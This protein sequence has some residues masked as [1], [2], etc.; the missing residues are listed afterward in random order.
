M[1]TLDYEIDTVDVSTAIL[2]SPIKEEV[3]MKIPSGYTDDP[4]GSKKMLPLP[5]C[6]YGLKQ[7][8]GL[9][10]ELCA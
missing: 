1:A 10:L 5:K 4:G 6:L 3:Y 8:I 2:L 9:G 7:G